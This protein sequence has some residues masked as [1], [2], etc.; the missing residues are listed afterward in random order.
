VDWPYKKI[1]LG[2]TTYKIPDLLVVSE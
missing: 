1:T 2:E